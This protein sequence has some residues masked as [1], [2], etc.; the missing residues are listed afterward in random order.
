MSLVIRPRVNYELTRKTHPRLR[1]DCGIILMIDG[2]IPRFTSPIIV[3]AIRYFM[4][5]LC[6]LGPAIVRLC[7]LGPAGGRI[8]SI[9][10]YMVVCVRARHGQC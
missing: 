5:W 1:S 6:V 4:L 2:K 7:V 8:A 3:I 9:G 10:I